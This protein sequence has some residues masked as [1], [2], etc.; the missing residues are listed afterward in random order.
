MNSFNDITELNNVRRDEHYENGRVQ[1]NSP[2]VEVFS[3][4]ALGQEI[5]EIKDNSGKIVN[6]NAAV[7]YIKELAHQALGGSNFAVSELNTIRKYTLWPLLQKRLQ[8]L[9]LFGNF[10]QVG[11][12]DTIMVEQISKVGELA[13]AQANR[14]DVIYGTT[15]RDS[16]IV[17]PVHIAAGHQV[18]YRA[19]ENGDMSVENMLLQQIEVAMWNKAA[20]Y[21]IYQLWNTV[22]NYDGVKFI[23]QGDGI[24]Q[25]SL[26]EIIRNIRRFGPVTIFGDYSVTAQLGGFLGYA[27]I[28]PVYG[29]ATGTQPVQVSGISQALVTD[30]L[31][32]GTV[33][34]YKGASVMTL[35]NEFDF[36]KVIYDNDGNPVTWDTL[37]PSG[38]LFVTPTGV[39]SPVQNWVVGGLT[40]MT[41]DE[42]KT[43]TVLTRFD[44]MLASDTVRNRIHEI[45]MIVDTNY[46]LPDN[47]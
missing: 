19:L 31:R 8:L 30:F 23:A 11:Y 41:A 44:L 28:T 32:N 22:S 20:Q 26:D 27:G 7:N 16:Y 15:D 34:N 2:I 25:S 6:V 39:S 43:G 21:C 46:S 17:K 1:Q 36:S 47:I 24:S 45:G 9:G 18:D 13:R 33:A 3:R 10:R 5:G 35:E 29:A 38:I 37:F 12:N 14:G 4:M 42:V 40:T